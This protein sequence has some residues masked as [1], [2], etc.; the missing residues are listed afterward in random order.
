M[1]YFAGSWFTSRLVDQDP[2]YRQSW[3]GFNIVF[4]IIVCIFVA[5]LASWLERG[6]RVPNRLIERLNVWALKKKGFGSFFSRID[7]L[8]ICKSPRWYK[9]F[10]NY[11]TL[12]SFPPYPFRWRSNLFCSGGVDVQH[13]SGLWSAGTTRPWIWPRYDT[14]TR[15]PPP[16]HLFFRF[17][18][19]SS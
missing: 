3:I 12:L 4:Q 13:G 19:T 9:F 6:T 7:T 1:D 14:P 15:P 16:P 18:S 8:L 10:F 11:S 5:H 2:D 17:K